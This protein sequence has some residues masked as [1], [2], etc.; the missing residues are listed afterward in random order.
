MNKTLKEDI[1]PYTTEKNS[2][3]SK[4]CEAQHKIYISVHM[5]QFVCGANTV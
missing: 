4:Y 5:I 2:G 3:S 1:H